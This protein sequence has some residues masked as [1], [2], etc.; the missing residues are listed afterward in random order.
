MIALTPDQAREL[1]EKGFVMVHV[2]GRPIKVTPDMVRFKR[3]DVI[4]LAERFM[5]EKSRRNQ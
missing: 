4:A 3:E 2:N 1:S 5:R